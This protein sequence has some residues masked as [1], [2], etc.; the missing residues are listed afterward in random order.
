MSIFPLASVL[1][2][3]LHSSNL[4]LYS[5]HLTKD[6]LTA[7]DYSKHVAKSDW[8][9]QPVP[10][11]VVQEKCIFCFLFLTTFHCKKYRIVKNYVRSEI[12]RGFNQLCEQMKK[13]SV[14]QNCWEILQFLNQISEVQTD[15]LWDES[16][17]SL[18]L[19]K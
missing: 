12:K 7:L 16:N 4:V 2:C 14:T 17:W 3:L 15:R 11:R 18:E 5:L 8:F 9:I 19:F 10:S 1:C 13:K 6:D